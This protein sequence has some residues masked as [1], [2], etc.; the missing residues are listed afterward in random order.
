MSE[1]FTEVA[2]VREVYLRTEGERPSYSLR[3]KNCLTPFP[4]SGGTYFGN[5]LEKPKEN[6]IAMLEMSSTP[7]HAFHHS[8]GK[9]HESFQKCADY[10]REQALESVVR[11]AKELFFREQ[12]NLFSLAGTVLRKTVREAERDSRHLNSEHYTAADFAAVYNTITGLHQVVQV[13][14]SSFDKLVIGTPHTADSKYGENLYVYPALELATNS[15]VLLAVN[16]ENKKVLA[17]IREVD[18]EETRKDVKSKAQLLK[19][20]LNFNF[21]R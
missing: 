20:R 3:S 9:L 1:N 13:A 16:P 4:I 12:M 15:L 19:K 5:E 8:L 10:Q 14:Q 6:L 17:E 11:D 18:L 21:E 7:Y 2:L